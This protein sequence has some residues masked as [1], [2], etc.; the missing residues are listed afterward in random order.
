[1][2]PLSW[3]F[4]LSSAIAAA[5]ALLACTSFGFAGEQATAYQVEAVYL[6]NFTKFVQWPARAMPVKSAPFAICILGA[7]PFGPVLDAALGGESIQGAQIVARRIAQPQDAAGCRIVFV[8]SSEEHR[9]KEIL[10]ALS[11]TGVLTVSDISDFTKRGGMI[12]FVQ[13][14]GKVRFEVNVKNATDAGLVLSADLIEV[15]LAVRTG[16]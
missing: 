12:Q 16:S 13:T 3:L 5:F 10:A 9:L 11:G 1:V 7:D 2:S 14:D 4:K 6:Y 15:A 8:S